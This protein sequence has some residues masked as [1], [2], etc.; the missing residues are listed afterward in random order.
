[1][2]YGRMFVFAF[3]VF[4]IVAALF[5]SSCSSC[6]QIDVNSVLA[7]RSSCLSICEGYDG[8]KRID[9]ECYCRRG[10]DFIKKTEIGN[11][12]KLC[13]DSYRIIERKCYCKKGEDYIRQLGTEVVED[14]E[15]YIIGKQPVENPGEE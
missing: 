10:E 4:G 14:R 7:T 13:P 5:F 9:D 12:D 11:C 2:S 8:F 3:F 1:M 6:D 15:V